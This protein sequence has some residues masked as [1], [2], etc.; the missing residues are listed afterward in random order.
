MDGPTEGAI[1]GISVGE[2]DG[3]VE[4][5]AVGATVG[6]IDGIAVGDAVGASEAEIP[7]KWEMNK[8]KCIWI[9]TKMY[10]APQILRKSGKNKNKIKQNKTKNFI[11]ATLWIINKLTCFPSNSKCI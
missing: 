6:P 5:D 7:W 1:D 3:S 4:G 10:S 8:I 11:I 9:T 2:R